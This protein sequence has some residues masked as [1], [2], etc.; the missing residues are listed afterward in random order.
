MPNS[1]EDIH[2]VLVKIQVLHP[3]PTI[4]ET[5]SPNSTSNEKNAF[6]TFQP[7]ARIVVDVT[8]IDRDVER[9]IPLRSPSR[10]SATAQPPQ[11]RTT[12]REFPPISKVCFSRPFAH[13]LRVLILSQGCWHGGFWIGLFLSLAFRIRV[14]KCPRCHAAFTCDTPKLVYITVRF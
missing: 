6:H 5:P 12:P 3:Q 13:S 7:A 4:S 14:S 9:E 11:E 8:T 10:R 2:E 1:L